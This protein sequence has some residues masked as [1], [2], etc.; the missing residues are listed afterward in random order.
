MTPKKRP[1][2]YIIR[3]LPDVVETRMRELF[4]AELNIDDT[5]RSE[6]ELVAAM[7]RVD[8][9]VPTVTDRI[10]APMI[11]QAGPQLKL[12]ASFSNGIDHVD[13][14]AAARKGITV[15][16]TPNVLTEDSADITMALVLAVPRRMIEGTRVLANGADEWLGWSPTWML[17]RRISGKRIGIVGMG[18]IGTAVARRAKAFGLSI[19]YHNRKRVNPATEAELEATYWDSLDQMLARVDIVSVN[20][21]STPATYHLISARRLALMQPTSYIVN[22]ARGDI[23]DE[24]AMIQCLREGKIAGAGLDVYENEPA[25]N[26]KLIKLAKEGK[27]VLLPHMGSATIEG[28]IEMGDKVIINIR[29]LFD[30]HRPP[31]RVLPGRN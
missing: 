31:N 13:V 22:T 25:V 4:D 18:R 28:R 21:P 7:Q 24:A 8:V 30:G 5:P 29:T 20:C 6:E 11:E 3:K 10:T 14:D 16:N 27:V 1:T 19:H 12:I 26:P 2:V 23:I 15:T 9:L 17:G